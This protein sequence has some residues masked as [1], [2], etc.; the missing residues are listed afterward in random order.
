MDFIIYKNSKVFEHITIQDLLPEITDWN[1]GGIADPLGQIYASIVNTIGGFITSAISSIGTATS[2]II[3]GATSILKGLI[4]G[5][6]GTINRIAATIGQLPQQI[7]SSISGIVTSIQ[8]VVG[9]IVS[10]IS[11]MVA[12]ISA[13]LSSGFSSLMLGINSALSGVRS[14]ISGIVSSVQST[15]SGIASSIAG[16]IGNIVSSISS[17]GASLSASIRSGFQSFMD[18]VDKIASSI[19]STANKIAGAIE[20]AF[21]SFVGK[22]QQAFAGF[23]FPEIKLPTLPTFEDFKK[24]ISDATKDIKFPTLDD[25][26]KWF[27]ELKLPTLDDIT[28]GVTDYFD[29]FDWSKVLK[30]PEEV[31]G[32]LKLGAKFLGK[33]LEEKSPSP[34]DDLINAIKFW[35][36]PLQAGTWEVAKLG[37]MGAFGSILTWFFDLKQVDPKDPKAGF[38]FEQKKDVTLNPFDAFANYLKDLG[39]NI[40]KGLT[41]F[42][43]AVM[44]GMNTVGNWIVDGVIKTFKLPTPDAAIK[45]PFGKI[46]NSIIQ[47]FS[48]F[49][50][51]LRTKTAIM[52]E[53]MTEAFGQ[54]VM[55]VGASEALEYT[56]LA[57]DVS[58]P[59]KNLQL[60]D[61]MEKF[62][63]KIGLGNVTSVIGLTL[64][65]ASLRPVFQR[66]WNKLSQVQL[67]SENVLIEMHRKGV[68]DE[69]LLNEYLSEHGLDSVFAKGLKELAWH[70]PNF[71][72]IADAYLRYVN[73]EKLTIADAEKELVK[74][75]DVYDY[76]PTARKGFSFSEREL[77]AKMLYR[78]VSRYERRSLN[79]TGMLKKDDLVKILR[80]DRL[81]PDLIEPLADAEILQGTASFRGQI[82]SK[83]TERV[84]KGFIVLDEFKK[85]LADAKFSSDMIGYGS[86]AQQLDIQTTIDEA[87]L[88][89]ADL[90]YTQAYIQRPEYV[91]IVTDVIKNEAIRKEHIAIADIA[92]TRF[93]KGTVRNE[94]ERIL[95]LFLAWLSEGSLSHAD[96]VYMAMG[97]KNVEL[98]AKQNTDLMKLEGDYKN[99][100]L[101]LDDYLNAV[102]G[103][104]Q[105]DEVVL[106]LEAGIMSLQAKIRSTKFKTLQTL[107]AKN[108]L[109]SLQFI[110]Q[111]VKLPV[112]KEYASCVKDRIV[113]QLLPKAK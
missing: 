40:V 56:G 97:L 48:G 47:L 21:T 87:R 93:D 33:M 113:S 39:S 9:G 90:N 60:K 80:A 88:K 102:Y 58:H 105:D 103:V 1:I 75:L 20:T 78:G 109:S 55:A 26:K 17:L 81:R 76:R 66:Y 64:V 32:F 101:K 112:D 3:S 53:L 2:Q 62:V 18:T 36:A 89:E 35:L 23:K 11:S 104:V 25:I 42:G 91:K 14:A 83:V 30:L 106:S 8:S 82:A 69:K 19:E 15:I 45:D 79:L 85:V 68:F 108:R 7:S 95:T 100:T 71:D 110:D 77:V 10:S 51:K 34:L 63:E 38:F 98:T 6:T 96:F 16:T 65:A 54:V 74:Y 86:T 94:Q 12:S 41:E 13:T 37:G 92:R 72:V 44:E 4:D 61:K 59:I 49:A 84:Q 70:I 107:L 67:P 99:G 24:W 22:V 111:S 50:K 52:P 28:K 73:E 29:K 46:F 31:L 5:I 27:S 57:V 43:T